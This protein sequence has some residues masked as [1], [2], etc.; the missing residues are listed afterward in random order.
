MSKIINGFSFFVLF[1]SANVLLFYHFDLE[2]ALLRGSAI[3]YISEIFLGITGLITLL[4]FLRVSSRWSGFLFLRK[5][6]N[7]I[8]EG[9][10]NS[11]RTQWALTVSGLELIFMF[12]FGVFFLFLDPVSFYLGLILLVL[13]T[14]KAVFLL[15][16]KKFNT[17]KIALSSKA[18]FYFEND[19]QTVPLVNAKKADFQSGELFITVSQDLVYKFPLYAV[20][21]EDLP[22]FG[23]SLLEIFSKKNVI[24]TSE[25]SRFLNC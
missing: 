25:L 22:L 7:F 1:V 15:L 17:F 12:A 9:R 13:T 18:I 10:I 21:K 11:E 16:S 2:I 4:L 8:W 23:K 3:P 5:I 24:V 14:E 19:L 6:K 20:K